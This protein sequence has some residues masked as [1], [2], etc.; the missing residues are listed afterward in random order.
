M[1]KDLFNLFRYDVKGEIVIKKVLENKYLFEIN[2][3][4]KDN[5][6]ILKRNQSL[7]GGYWLDP[8]DNDVWYEINL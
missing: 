6:L 8:I 1:S 4:A 5:A 7:F 2:Q 3:Y